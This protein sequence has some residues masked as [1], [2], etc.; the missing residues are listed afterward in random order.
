MEIMQSTGHPLSPGGE[1]STPSDLQCE[2]A[3]Q[4]VTRLQSG[5]ATEGTRLS[6]PEL[7]REFGVSR[8]PMQGA[9]SLL[10]RAG[11]LQPAS[12]RGLE[13]AVD[14]GTIDID[15]VVPASPLEALYRR[16]MRDRATGHL[17]QEVSETELMP[18]YEISR[19]TVR[20]LLMRFSA[21]GL[22][23]RQPGHGWRFADMLDD[24]AE[25]ESYEIRQ[26]VE[27]ASL[28]S[29]RFA[30]DA[31]K[32]AVMR[33]AHEKILGGSIDGNAWFRVNAEFHE[34]LVGFSQNRFAVQLIHQQNNL[35]RMGEAAAFETL[36]L[37]RIHQSCEEHMA[38]LDAAEA[39]DLEWAAA[40]LKRH[41]QAAATF[42]NDN[43]HDR[44]G[45]ASH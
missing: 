15:A 32:A 23:R 6:V 42:K 43:S 16:I 34:G 8:S 41:L 39:G 27:C 44:S 33:R 29:P 11:V 9:L 19:G 22:A 13:V 38:I 20:K 18:L 21:E 7:A 3:R 4:V 5:G 36:P 45:S 12:P 35:R 25:A 2:L 1:E 24:E 10:A 28:L 30:F 14:I 37:A 40:L 26:M 17:P 31:E